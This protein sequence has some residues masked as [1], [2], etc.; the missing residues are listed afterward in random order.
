MGD[1][2]LRQV[3]DALA[4]ADR[5]FTFVVWNT[6]AISYSNKLSNAMKLVRAELRHRQT[7]RAT[8]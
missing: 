2:E 8:T 6:A 1:D 5:R 4:A 3:L 7:D